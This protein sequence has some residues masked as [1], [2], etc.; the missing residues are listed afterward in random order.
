MNYNLPTITRALTQFRHSGTIVLEKGFSRSQYV[1][2]DLSESNPQ[3]QFVDMSSAKAIQQ[4]IDVVLEK[5]KGKV[6]YGGYL[7]PRAIY[8]RSGHFADKAS[9]ERNIHLGV[10][11]WCPSGTAVLACLRGRVHSFQDNRAFGDY[12][13]TII[14]EHELNNSTF[15]TLYGHLSRRSLEGLKVGSYVEQG[16][17]IAA[18]GEPHEN[19]DYAPHLHFQIIIDL[20]GKAGDYPGVC[21]A[22]ELAFFRR[23]CPDP[24]IL[25]QLT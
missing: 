21:S 12:G 10:D 19:G 20:N 3:L 13:P 14:L 17:Q 23:N 22:T 18:L 6:A 15:Y 7:E 8:R 24:N 2:L 25:L 5:G 9:E 11:L 16:E 1:P 4:Y